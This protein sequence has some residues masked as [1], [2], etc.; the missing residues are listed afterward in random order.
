MKE[1]LAR[2]EVK[3]QLKAERRQKQEA[4]VERKRQQREAH[5]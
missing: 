1:I 3:L 4:N 5:R 2:K